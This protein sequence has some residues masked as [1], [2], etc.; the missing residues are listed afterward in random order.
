MYIRSFN[1]KRIIALLLACAL[2]FTTFISN[3]DVAEAKVKVQVGG[4]ISVKQD[5]LGEM[6]VTLKNNSDIDGYFIYRSTDPDSGFKQ[7]GEA[8]CY[9]DNMGDV[10]YTEYPREEESRFYYKA[11][12]YKY[13]KTYKKKKA[14]GYTNTSSAAFKYKLIIE[15][16]DTKSVKLRFNL[17]SDIEYY[18]ICRSETK[19]GDYTRI[20]SG[21]AG[22]GDL[23]SYTDTGL[24]L[25]KKY[26]YKVMK[27]E[28]VEVTTTEAETT[29]EPSTEAVT[30]EEGIPY[31]PISMNPSDDEWYDY[32]DYDD[33]DDDDYD[34]NPVTYEYVDIEVVSSGEGMTG[35]K[36]VT[37]TSAKVASKS[38]MNINW[39]RN[40][41]AA[42]YKIYQ[43]KDN[44]SY[45]L[46]K[47]IDS[48]TNKCAIGGF[49][50]GEI[51]KINVVPYME[52]NGMKI[53]GAYGDSFDALM[54]YYGCANESSE[55]KSKRIFGNKG[56]DYRYK[57]AK[58]AA[59]HMTTIKIKC[60]DFASGKSGRKITKTFSVTVNKKIAPTLKKAFDEI[61]HGKEKFPI[62]SIGGF[63]YYTGGSGQHAVGLAVDIN[64][65]ENPEVTNGKVTVGGKYEPG[66][67]PYSIPT[68]GEVARI[69][70]KYGFSQGLW[71]SKQ[72]YMH[73]SY[74]GI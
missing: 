9:W 11:K 41:N 42:G 57:D 4:I 66:K 15:P 29:E 3:T 25:G 47:T 50:H 5:N 38:T 62:H 63:R 51:K 37:I 67:N 27:A 24:E 70:N 18:S 1:K 56:S 52:Y 10:T 34:Y 12:A 54:N 40:K 65:M 59:A 55:A 22:Y 68:D 61:Y 8:Y 71:S 58:D 14:S 45:K 16:I 7:V 33:Y 35:P 74:F 69:M 49:K 73:F 19:S 64:P 13:T 26:Y 44:G 72:D 53:N 21:G 60:W 36:A 39:K 43:C 46:L 17:T 32:D 30:T 23:F 28:R 2:V 20:Y 31:T 6:V 48:N